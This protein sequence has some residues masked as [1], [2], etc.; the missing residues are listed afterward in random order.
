MLL[1]PSIKPNSPPSVTSFFGTTLTTKTAT[2]CLMISGPTSASKRSKP[3]GIAVLHYDG[4]VKRVYMHLSKPSVHI[5]PL[6]AQT[7]LPE[8]STCQA[9]RTRYAACQKRYGSHGCRW[10]HHR[11]KQACETPLSIERATANSYLVNP[12]KAGIIYGK[13]TGELFAGFGTILQTPL[14]SH[15]RINRHA[16]SSLYPTPSRPQ[17]WVSFAAPPSR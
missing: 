3:T 6:L 17:R 2:A 7:D 13:H 9:Q 10:S 16:I 15:L 8:N 1:E 14:P 4:K 11:M 12:R 5:D